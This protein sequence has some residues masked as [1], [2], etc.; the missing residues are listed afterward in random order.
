MLR[1][2]DRADVLRLVVGSTLPAA[3][4]FEARMFEEV[5]P[6]IMTT[7]SYI[8]GQ[9]TSLVLAQVVTQIGEA[10]RAIGDAN[11]AIVE[12]NTKIAELEKR[13]DIALA[14]FDPTQTW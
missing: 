8:N 3:Q 10:I 4:R 12:Q 7:G 9:S 14:G 11:I 5:L 1:T 13:L 6:S 2:L